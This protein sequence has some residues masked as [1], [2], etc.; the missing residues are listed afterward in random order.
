M[1]LRIARAAGVQDAPAFREKFVALQLDV[2]QLADAYAVFADRLVRGEQL[3]QDV[4]LLK[5]WSTET[6]QRIADLSIETAGPAA[7][8]VEDV[9]FGDEAVNILG[10]W[11]KA[12][13][14][15]IYGGSNEIQRHIVARNVL[16][17][18]GR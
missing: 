9:P 6:F 13:P 14:A 8:L 16:N 7:S 17:L 10:P 18:P 4:S 3:G 15:T 1:L 11:Y 2:V 5:I 12:R